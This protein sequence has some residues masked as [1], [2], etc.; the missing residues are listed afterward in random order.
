MRYFYTHPP[1]RL[2]IDVIFQN[3]TREEVSSPNM[4][5]SEGRG[6]CICNIGTPKLNYV[7]MKILVGIVCAINAKPVSRHI[8]KNC[9][10]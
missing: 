9:N 1:R 4:S 2:E 6:G 3:S 10:H 8:N 5:Q 7:K